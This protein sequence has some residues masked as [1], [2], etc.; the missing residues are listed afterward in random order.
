MEPDPSR[1]SVGTC[2]DKKKVEDEMPDGIRVY[3]VYGCDIDLP[4]PLWHHVS[5]TEGENINSGKT[6]L[7]SGWHKYQHWLG[8]RVFHYGVIHRFCHGQQTSLCVTHVEA[9]RKGKSSQV[10]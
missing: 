9:L 10:D 4:A 7:A 6:S 1:L 5:S 2:R 3:L 8:W